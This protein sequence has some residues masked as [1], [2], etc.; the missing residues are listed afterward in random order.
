[1]HFVVLFCLVLVQTRKVRKS[2]K[3][4]SNVLKNSFGVSV[5]VYSF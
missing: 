2:I 1:M 3:F 4:K 5:L